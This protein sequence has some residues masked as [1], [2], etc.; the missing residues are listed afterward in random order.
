MRLTGFK[1]RST[2]PRHGGRYHYEG[3][4]TIDS[5]SHGRADILPHE[6]GAD[7]DVNTG[8]ASTRTPSAAA[9]SA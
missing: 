6:S 3:S 8:R 5:Y 4:I 7:P 2:A 9:G 1:S